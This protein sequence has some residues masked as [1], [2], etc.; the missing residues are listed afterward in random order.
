MLYE[1]ITYFEKYL[2]TAEAALEYR[3]YAIFQRKGDL[4]MASRCLETVVKDGR[5]P[6]AV[7]EK[8]L[9]QLGR[10]LE[11]MGFEDAARD[12]YRQFV[13]D[14]PKSMMAPKVQARLAG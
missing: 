8:G 5:T 1:V 6:P 11:E 3:L 13:A 10:M 14:F 7:R 2:K 9:F 12:A 4:D